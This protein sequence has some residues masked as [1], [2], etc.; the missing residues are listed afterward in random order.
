MWYNKKR[1]VLAEVM[2]KQSDPALVEQRLEELRLLVDTYGWLSVVEVVQ[3]RHKPDYQTYIGSGKLEETIE[4]MKAHDAWVLI[5]GNILKP[6]QIYTLNKTLKEHNLQAWDRVDLILKIFER[7]ATSTEAKL[8]VELAAIKHMGPRIFGMGMELSRQWGWSKL[9]R[10]IGETNTE[11]MNRH[12]ATKRKQIEKELEKYESVRAVHRASRERSNLPTVWLVWYTNAWKSSLMNVLTDKDVL[13]EDKLF[14]TLGTDVGQ[15]YF[16]S[17]KG[18][19]TTVLVNDTIWFIRDL[20]PS[21]IKAFKS[22]LED[23]VEADLLFHVADAADE[24]IDDKIRV[25]DEILKQIGADQKRMLIFNKID[26]VNNLPE[27]KQYLNELAEKY[28]YTDVHY[29]SA[30]NQQ[31]TDELIDVIRNYYRIEEYPYD[32]G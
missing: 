15:L 19:W 17:I 32:L 25:V 31:W 27:R 10:W 5:M 2:P 30:I 6:S 14:A 11:I 1:I 3:Q 7:H 21:L 23:S 18:K 9:A 26:Q 8:Q 13:V 16:P 28:E 29:I 22:T 4:L 12:L 24:L 20:P